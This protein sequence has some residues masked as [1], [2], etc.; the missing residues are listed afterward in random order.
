MQGK[1]QSRLSTQNSS[2]VFQSG[3]LG[4]TERQIGRSLRCFE[5]PGDETK[6]R[7]GTKCSLAARCRAFSA[8][9]S[10]S[11]VSSRDVRPHRCCRRSSPCIRG[12]P[13][14]YVLVLLFPGW[15]RLHRRARQ[16]FRA[17]REARVKWD[18]ARE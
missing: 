7:L 6:C 10:A 1:R 4:G 13:E 18:P 16:Q 3:T 2:Y 17:P 11:C 9:S 12:E 14:E 5:F 15:N 8:W